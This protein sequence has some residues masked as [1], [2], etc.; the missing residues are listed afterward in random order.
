MSEYDRITI[1]GVDYYAAKFLDYTQ[2]DPH[3]DPVTAYPSDLKGTITLQGVVYRSD[4]GM[5]LPATDETFPASVDWVRH[6][7][8]ELPPDATR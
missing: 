6:R 7:N 3:I 2:T 5:Q 1:A 4:H 8:V